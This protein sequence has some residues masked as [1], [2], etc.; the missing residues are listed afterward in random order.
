MCSAFLILDFCVRIVFRSQQV[1]KTTV[2]ICTL[3]T[4]VE[5]PDSTDSLGS[6]LVERMPLRILSTCHWL[7]CEHNVIS[8]HARYSKQISSEERRRVEFF[9]LLLHHPS[10]QHRNVKVCVDAS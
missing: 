5:I 4:S 1:P 7:I 10:L 9:K 6:V 8:R 3:G 2:R